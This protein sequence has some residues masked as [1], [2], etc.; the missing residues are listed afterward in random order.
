M[1]RL[2]K[3]D[4]AEEFSL[5]IRQE[6]KNYNDSILTTNMSI[7]KLFAEI[8]QLKKALA[9]D[10]NDYQNELYV[11]GVE[12]GFLKKKNEDAIQKLKGIIDEN[13]QK[14]L[15]NL[16]AIRKSFDDRESYYLRVEGF[17]QFKRTLEKWM[18]NI[19]RMFEVQKDVLRRDI[20]LSSEKLTAS[21]ENTQTSLHIKIKEES[22]LRKKNEG[23]FDIFALHFDS[24]KTEIER[25]KKRSFIVEK[26]IENLY[27][28]QERMKV[29]L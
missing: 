1:A 2:L 10:G 9:K 20:Q 27:T 16:K 12:I 29:I 13:H 7:N 26:E 21:L 6:I 3:R 17:D 28:Q 8:E 23:N 5:I 18:A 4:L 14:N 15:D 24:L 25:L 11:H 22:D 19:Q